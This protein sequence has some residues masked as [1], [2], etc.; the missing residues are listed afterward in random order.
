MIERFCRWWCRMFHRHI[1]LPFCGQYE[2]LR[3]FRT[4]PVRWDV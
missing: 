2:C 3:C 1:T 4:Y